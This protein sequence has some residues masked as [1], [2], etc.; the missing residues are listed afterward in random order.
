LKGTGIVGCEHRSVSTAT[1]PFPVYPTIG[2]PRK[3]CPIP[4]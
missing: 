4:R 1:S 3:P 2:G